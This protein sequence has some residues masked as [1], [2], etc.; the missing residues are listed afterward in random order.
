M[1][2]P[3]GSWA[4]ICAAAPGSVSVPVRSSSYSIRVF[5]VGFYSGG[6]VH[7][8]FASFSS[9]VVLLC[10]HYRRAARI[11]FRLKLRLTFLNITQYCAP[12]ELLDG[13]VA[14][15][16]RS[17]D[18]ILEFSARR[19]REHHDVHLQYRA[20]AGPIRQPQPLEFGVSVSVSRIS[21]SF[22]LTHKECQFRVQIW[23]LIGADAA[24]KCLDGQGQMLLLG[25]V[26]KHSVIITILSSVQK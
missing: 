6:I 10:A 9:L 13:S 15:K 17:P 26:A 8:D 19:E 1:R 23:I 25:I 14:E 22:A 5:G 20:A 24:I 16:S 3:Y 7:S 4:C 12:A 2:A 11:I 18:W 21:Y